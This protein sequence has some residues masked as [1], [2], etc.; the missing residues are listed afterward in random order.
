MKLV[1]LLMLTGLTSLTV[2]AFAATDTATPTSA[3]TTQPTIVSTQEQP[4]T[5]L[6]KDPT[7]T[8]DASATASEP[9]TQSP[10]TTTKHSKKH[11]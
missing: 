11:H 5:T 2:S 7:L 10:A 9:S 8:S 3:Q 6:A 4:Q 1:K